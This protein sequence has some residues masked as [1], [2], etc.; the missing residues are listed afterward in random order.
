M[1]QTSIVCDSESIAP[2]IRLTCGHRAL[3]DSGLAEFCEVPTT[4]LNEQI[5]RN[6]NQI[7]DEFSLRYVVKESGHVRSQIAA[8]G[9][10]LTGRRF[11]SDGS[12]KYATVMAATALNSLAAHRIERDGVFAGRLATAGWVGQ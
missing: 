1:K 6:I 7:P 3:L 5:R 12:S 9:S 4:R 8:S 10:W 11:P 2:Q